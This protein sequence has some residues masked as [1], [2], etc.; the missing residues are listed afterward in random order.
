MSGVGEKRRSRFDRVES[1]PET[2]KAAID[3]S[4]VAARAAEM[5]RELS[6]K[7]AMVTSQLNSANAANLLKG[8]GNLGESQNEKRPVY[9]AL[10]LDSQGREIDEYGN[11]V[12]S[13]AAQ[14]KTL[15]AN[16]AVERANKKKENPYLAHRVIPTAATAATAVQNSGLVS[17][18]GT[19]G[20]A[21][22]GLNGVVPTAAV[23]N[24][25]SAGAVEVVDERLP[26]LRRD[27]RARKALH[28]IEAGTLV[29]EA[30]KIKM[31]EERKIIAGYASGRKNIQHQK[32]AG[33]AEG[34]AEQDEETAPAGAPHAENEPL[35]A[36]TAVPAYPDLVVPSLEWWDEAFLPKERRD[37]RKVSKAA[38]LSAAEDIALLGLQHARTHKLVQH[39]VPVRP[40]GVGAAGE[41]PVVLPMFLTKQERKKLRR[42]S[43]QE[44]EL[45]KRDK[46]MMG[47]IPAP[48]PKFTLNN[49]MKVLGDQA[50]A[51]PSLVEARVLQQMQKRV[52]NHEMRN[53]AAKLTP[54]ERKEKRVKKRQEDTSRS[55]NVAVFRVRDFVNLKHR[56]KVDVNAQQLFLS[57]IVLLCGDSSSDNLVVAEGGP[58]GIRKF[59]KLMT[60]RINWTEPWVPSNNY[61][62]S[63]ANADQNNSSSDLPPG[64]S[65]LPPGVSAEE[66][67][68][69]ARF[70]QGQEGGEG[71]EEEDGDSD[72]EDEGGDNNHSGAGTDFP[73]GSSTTNA[74]GQHQ[75]LQQEA[76][77]S[78]DNRCDL[79][80]QG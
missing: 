45:E 67:M 52:L 14:V 63:K 31:K 27:L 41:R 47:L 2:K 51:D 16:V 73:A 22:L 11:V 32:A 57:G 13:G 39:P 60:Q 15:A 3:V 59:I 56:F 61:S 4:A 38:L 78:A 24:L 48:E 70:Y 76:V 6:S 75:L 65:A 18:G 58:K 46:M 72:A 54:A 77:S 74:E 69:N 44:R 35:V 49:F 8:P 25:A 37:A 68:E 28:F 19:A 26:Q 62:I 64:M 80:W 34:S 30:E 50:V 71:E 7:I 23:T 10:V 53:Q 66:A 43:R 20:T 40:L 1:E 5:S 55:V 29:D 12:K 36:S 79:L 21:S 33:D 42:T 17:A 9:R